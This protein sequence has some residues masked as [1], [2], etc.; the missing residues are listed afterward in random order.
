MTVRSIDLRAFQTQTTETTTGKHGHD[1]AK[2]D[3]DKD[4]QQGGTTKSTTTTSHP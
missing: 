2:G 1:D 4:D 3:N